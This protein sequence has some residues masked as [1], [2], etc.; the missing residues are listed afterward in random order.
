M[1]KFAL[2][3]ALALLGTACGIESSEINQACL[4]YSGG[5][6]QEKVFESVLPAGS[7][8][9]IV[10]LGSTSTCYNTDQRTFIGGDG[11][12]ADVEPI[13]IV[14]QDQQQL[15]SEFEAYFTLNQNVDVL[16]AFHENL[17]VKTEAWTP[18]GWD[19]L[20]AQYFK[21]SIER[22]LESAAL[23]Y[24]MIPLYSSEAA[25]RDFAAST[26]RDFQRNLDEVIGG[27]YF[28]GPEH[29]SPEDP[30]GNITLAVGRPTIL[31]QETV[32]AL[33]IEPKNRALLAAQEVE[34]QRIQKELEATAAQVELYGQCGYAYIR[35][36]EAA[37]EAGQAIPP[38]YGC[39]D[40]E[41]VQAVPLP[42]AN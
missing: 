29:Q 13:V 34:N 2:L 40:S 4:I 14:S 38:F 22:A 9:E 36:V 3:L 28:C 27:N 35:G 23:E 30:C 31:N 8:N 16:R 32:Q 18:E 17:G 37:Q 19:R 33:E 20:L 26:I 41:R 25:R 7:T 6:T 24:E 1:R 11:A 5:V 21:P 12:G 15:G 42:S 10:G 39:A